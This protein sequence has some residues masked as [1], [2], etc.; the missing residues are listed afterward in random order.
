M[1]QPRITSI[2]TAVPLRR[3]SQAEIFDNFLAR[4]F[5]RPAARGIFKHAGV[6]YR[7]SAADP[8]FYDTEPTTQTRVERYLQEA[9][10]LGEQAIACCLK[11]AG[12]DPTQVDDL[13]IV[14]CTGF[15]TPGLDLRLAASLGMRHE[16]RRA[17]IFG[18]GCYGSFP[19]LARASDAILAK[20]DRTVLILALELCSLH[21]QFEESLEI[22]VASALFADGAAAVLLTGKDGVEP[23]ESLSARLVDAL[24]YSDYSTLD[25][26]AMHVTDHGFRMHLSPEVPASLGANVGSI[27]E[28][29]LT[30]NDLTV[31][32]IRFWGVHPGS[33]K[34]IDVVQ[35][36]LGLDPAQLDFSRGILREYGNMS[37][38]TI[39][40]ILDEIQRCGRPEPGDYGVLMAFGPGLTIE[41]LL[42]R[43]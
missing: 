33:S 30:R 32:A 17:S 29:L 9:L 25:Q 6:D 4:R 8:A 20:P 36:T 39:L 31:G 7:Y 15:D 38:P 42:V 18:M 23:A 5:R 34:I 37:S 41:L 43:W 11:R 16:L 22:I 28:R 27:V 19:A 21:L 3:Y 2:G 40:F 26:M 1:N 13:L 24:T 14:S 35:A 10:P 12:I